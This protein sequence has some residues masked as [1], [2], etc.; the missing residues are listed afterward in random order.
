MAT[1][2]EMGGH[3]GRISDTFLLWKKIGSL[4]SLWQRS[5]W[6]LAALVYIS[7]RQIKWVA[8]KQ[9]DA[10]RYNIFSAEWLLMYE[11]IPWWGV[12]KRYSRQ[13]RPPCISSYWRIDISFKCQEYPIHCWSLAPRC[14]KL[15]RSFGQKID[16]LSLLLLHSWNTPRQA[17][18]SWN[19]LLLF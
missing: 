15:R 18:S 13:I 19:I 12:G 5:E 6:N 9:L 16:H 8:L 17:F 10:S 11:C 2:V 14:E 3:G 4:N 1:V 7:I